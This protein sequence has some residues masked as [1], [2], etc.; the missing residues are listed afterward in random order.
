MIDGTTAWTGAELETGALFEVPKENNN[1]T[2]TDSS[3][4]ENVPSI[5]L[6][7]QINNNN[8]VIDPEIEINSDT[9]INRSHDPL[10]SNRSNSTV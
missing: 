8:E 4:S 2:T 7:S 10:S 3:S 9:A 6:E 5:P 1:H